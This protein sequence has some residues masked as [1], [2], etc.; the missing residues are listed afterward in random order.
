MV[1]GIKKPPDASVL[2]RRLSGSR[3]AQGIEGA[4]KAFFALRAKNEA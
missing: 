4:L 1:A 2:P 3:T